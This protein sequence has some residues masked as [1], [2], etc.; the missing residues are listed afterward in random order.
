M[1]Y[2]DGLGMPWAAWIQDEDCLPEMLQATQPNWGE[3]GCG[4][5]AAAAAA[6]AIYRCCQR[7]HDL[8]SLPRMHTDACA[9]GR[10]LTLTDW[11]KAV[12]A[13]LGGPATCSLFAS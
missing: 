2:L 13:Q 9:N 6:F 8:I 1:A 11:G 4:A 7:H 12:R 10:P 5:T 3:P